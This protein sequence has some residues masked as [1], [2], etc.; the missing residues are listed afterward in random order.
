MIRV[1]KVFR[2]GPRQITV[3]AQPIDRARRLDAAGQ[4]TDHVFENPVPKI[5]CFDRLAL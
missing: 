4:Y 2:Y 5:A 1:G 3:I